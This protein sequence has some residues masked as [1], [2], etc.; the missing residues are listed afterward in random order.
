MVL[1]VYC[2]I[3]LLTFFAHGILRWWALLRIRSV[4]KVRGSLA[5][6]W[7]RTSVITS[8]PLLTSPVSWCLW[9]VQVFHMCVC[10]CSLFF[11]V[12]NDADYTELAMSTVKQTQAIP[13][14][15]PF[16]LLL[17][18]LRHLTGVYTCVC[19][20]VLCLN[21]VLIVCV[22]Q[23]MWRRLRRQRRAR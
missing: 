10:V 2:I 20:C 7:K 4:H 16:P 5:S 18:Q 13:F 11:F 8:S 3:L 21:V 23:V 14:T 19:V 15:G 9:S 12:P 22:L 1:T 17:N 6:W